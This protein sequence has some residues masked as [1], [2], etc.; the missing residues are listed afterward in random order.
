MAS[1]LRLTTLANNA[2]TESVD[3][4]Y[5]ING[6]AKLW[7]SFANT[8]GTPSALQ[9]LNQSSITDSG[10]GHYGINTTN[11]F[12]NNEYSAQ[13]TSSAEDAYGGVAVVDLGNMTAS[14][15][16]FYTCNNNASAVSDFDRNNAQ[17]HGDL[18]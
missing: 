15:L 11:A 9:S 4:T 3:T 7:T 8:S 17:A 10:V 6:S 18:A 14:Q 2:G 5:V 1:E 12:T 16:R 13:T